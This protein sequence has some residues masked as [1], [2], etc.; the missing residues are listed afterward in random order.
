MVQA[1]QQSNTRS[2]YLHQKLHI[3]AVSESQLC[4]KIVNKR[5]LCAAE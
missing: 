2:V 3:S 4:G 5:A 1:G